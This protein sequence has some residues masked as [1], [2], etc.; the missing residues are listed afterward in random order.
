M[1]WDFAGGGGLEDAICGQKRAYYPTFE[2]STLEEP[3]DDADGDVD[4]AHPVEKKRRLSFDQVRSLERNFEM[5]NK[6]EPERKM[7]LAKELGLQPRQVAVW[8]QNRRARW[9]TKQLERD[10]EMLNSGY[11]KLKADFEAALREKDALKAKVVYLHPLLSSPSIPRLMD[12]WYSSS[13][14]LHPNP[15]LCPI[16]GPTPLRQSHLPGLTIRRRLLPM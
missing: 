1:F 4:L 6:L 3:E 2:G 7:Q 8:F 15:S 9:K 16:S 13:K 12:Q 14:T 10:Y 5:E 11:L